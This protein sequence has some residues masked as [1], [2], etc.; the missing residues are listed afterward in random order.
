VILLA[1]KYSFYPDPCLKIIDPISDS[2]K[3]SCPLKL[4][5]SYSTLAP[6]DAAALIYSVSF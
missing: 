1:L 3:S 5:A 6:D 4:R 2:S